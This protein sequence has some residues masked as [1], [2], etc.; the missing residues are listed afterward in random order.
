MCGGKISTTP[1]LDLLTL[2]VTG[3][4]PVLKEQQ[5]TRCTPKKYADRMMAPRLW[6]S[7]IPQSNSH[8]WGLSG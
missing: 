5:R 8:N 7:E 4:D 2:G 6:A 3:A 1:A